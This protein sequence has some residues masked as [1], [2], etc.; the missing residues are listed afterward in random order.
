M[1]ASTIVQSSPS[2]R[3]HRAP[4]P[5]IVATMSVTLFCVGLYF[6]TSFNGLPYFPGPWAPSAEIERYF[7]LRAPQVLLCAFFQFGSAIPLGIFA[8]SATDR[9]SFLGV[10]AAGIE[11]ARFGGL[12]T[13]V[14]IATSSGILWAMTGPA[15]S[16]NAGAVEALYFV[17][18]ALGGFGFSIS[19]GLLIAGLAVPSYFARLL[20]RWF[21]FVGLAIALCGELSWLEM[22]APRLLP[23]IPLTRFPGFVWIIVAGFLLPAHRRRAKAD[24]DSITR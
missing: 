8:A 13:T 21:V 1:T 17:S 14:L 10:R 19:F 11:I 22:V 3:R 4:P 5:G 2:L 12:M 24:D 7:A 20:P 16:H 9:L 18:F 15:V 23:L 6:V